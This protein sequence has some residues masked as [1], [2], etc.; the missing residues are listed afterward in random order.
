[1]GRAYTA[2]FRLA[3]RGWPLAPLL[4]AATLLPGLISLT[5]AWTWLSGALDNALASRTLLAD[6]DL[7]VFVDLLVHHAERFSE[8]STGGGLLL[9]VC[10][11]VW[12]WL[13]AI[14]VV[15]VTEDVPV[16]AAAGR[17]AQVYPTFLSL[18]VLTVALDAVVAG[19]AYGLGQ[20]LTGWTAESP[21]EMTFYWVV[22]GCAAAAAAV[23]LFVTVVHDHARIHSVATGT[24]ALGAWG[25]AVQFVGWRQG[26]ALPL[27]LSILSTG[28]VLWVVYQ[29]VGMLIHTQ[30]TSGVTVS[31]LWGEFM[32]LVRAFLRVWNFAAA[33]E[34]QNLSESA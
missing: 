14:A 29:T 25:W 33:S 2:G 18:W 23:V 21:D 13:N 34:L 22:G 9:V 26:R 20:V 6:L 11:L 24:G 1:M 5:V 30:S 4:F 31:L 8:L 28:A 10:A 32:M 17:A 27:A 3:L 15:A 12:I 16:R 19:G 7:N